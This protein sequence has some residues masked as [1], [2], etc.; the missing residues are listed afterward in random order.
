MFPLVVDLTGR[1]VVVIGAG[2]V[3]VH[4]ATQLL[5][6]GARVTMI[7]EELLAPVPDGV[8]ELLLRPYEYGDLSGAVLVVA[9]TGSNSVNDEIVRETTERNLLLNVVDDLARSN[10]FFT[11]VHRDGDV[12]VSVS[13][14]G[15]SP[16]L[17]QWVRATA[18][19]ALPTNLARVARQLRDERRALHDRGES[20]EGRPWMDRVHELLGESA[21]VV[22]DASVFT[23]ADLTAEIQHQG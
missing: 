12:V 14:G 1:R 2:K 19:R 18:A 16:A 13:T 21:H 4:K 7:S 6:C 3:G 10:F 11:A 23:R 5:E 17:A 20:T 8:E 15:A 9:A 22:D